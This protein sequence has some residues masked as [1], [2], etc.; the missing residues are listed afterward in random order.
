MNRGLTV[1][2]KYQTRFAKFD[3]PCDRQSEATNLTKCYLRARENSERISAIKKRADNK[4][5]LL[6]TNKRL[7]KLCQ[8][9]LSVGQWTQSFP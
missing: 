9:N 3:I 7:R 4:L 2:W 5:Y 8:T 6:R 1:V